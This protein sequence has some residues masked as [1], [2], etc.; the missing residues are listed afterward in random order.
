MS[1]PM[2]AAVEHEDSDFVNA[3]RKHEPA[4]TAEVAEEVGISRQGADYRLRQLEDRGCVES[5][6]PGH[7]LIWMSAEE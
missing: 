1:E 3:V 2:V 7:D 4:T 6:K 5:K